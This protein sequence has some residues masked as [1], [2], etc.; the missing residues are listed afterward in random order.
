MD[1]VVPGLYASPPQPLPFAPSLEMR[2]FLCR[3]EPGNLLV[4]GTSGLEAQVPAIERLGGASR[5]Y[6]NHGHEAEV[7]S[8]D[9]VS[10]RFVHR[11]DSEALAAKFGVAEA[12]SRR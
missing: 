11:D 6:F 2:S 5:H 7:A 1:V 12:F 10:P 8:A 3:R 9:L 4:Y